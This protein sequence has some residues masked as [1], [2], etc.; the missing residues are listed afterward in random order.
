MPN[1]DKSKI[2]ISG[3]EKNATHL[4]G[5]PL[6]PLGEMDAMDYILQTPDDINEIRHRLFGFYAQ[7]VPN[8]FILY[9]FSVNLVHASKLVI[10]RPRA[11]SSWLCTIPA[12]LGVIFGLFMAFSLFSV[13]IN[14]RIFAWYANVCLLTAAICNSAIMLQKAYLV[15]CRQRWVL[16]VGFGLMLPQTGYIY[17]SWA[18]TI[19]T[20]DPALGCVFNYPTFLPYYW[21]GTEL[22]LNILFSCIFIRVAYQQYRTF[23]SEAWKRLA[24]DGVQTMIW[25]VL[26][27]VI[28]IT[29]IVLEVGKQ[30][31]QLFFVVNWLVIS[32]VLIYHCQSMRQTSKLS[33]RPNTENL[34]VISQIA[35]AK[36]GP[37]KENS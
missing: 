10:H 20:L 15:Q 5:I 6:H 14:C 34:M 1:I 22:P 4:W 7:L 2:I 12:L 17:Y 26:C 16:I 33:N 25:A 27:N 8:M 13:G 3:W 23:G 29:M 37:P 31:S 28:C 36:S 32:K 19:M 11:V 18:T 21:F 24:H 30:F 9:M 35:T